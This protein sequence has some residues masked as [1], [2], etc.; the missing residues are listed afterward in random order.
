MKKI[1]EGTV[2]D[3]ERN[4]VKNMVKHMKCDSDMDWDVVEG[5]VSMVM[6]VEGVEEE[7]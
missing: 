5:T 2:G 7:A 6:N 4:I 3:M 1:K